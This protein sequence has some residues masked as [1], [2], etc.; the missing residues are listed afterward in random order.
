MK[1]L[2][3]LLS[4]ALVLLPL[5]LATVSCGE[6]ELPQPEAPNSPTEEHNDEK[7]GNNGTGHD[8]GGQGDN[9]DNTG[10]GGDNQGNQN[11]GQGGDNQGNPNDGQGGGNQG[12]GDGAADNQDKQF[13]RA[14]LT[15]DGHL[16]IDDSFYLSLEEYPNVPSAQSSQP[17]A[18][19]ELA[20]AYSEGDLT[21][22]HIPTTDEALL[23]RQVLASESPYYGKDPLPLL[24]KELD[25]LGYIPIYRERYL[26]DE[27]R[28][29]FD[30][31]LDTNISAAAKSKT[32][33]L[34]LVRAK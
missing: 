15:A 19:A 27:A 22:W 23:L 29:A 4:F 25:A 8:D 26:C 24:N 10:Q 16:L 13:G 34:R 1:R 32:Y 21:S 7:P 12:N 6:I 14:K 31:E 17:K 28:K 9:K 18:A 20:A 30:F 2:V 5:Q 11:D 33:R 3:S